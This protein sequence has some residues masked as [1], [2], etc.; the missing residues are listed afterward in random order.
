MIVLYRGAELDVR[1]KEES[2]TAP[3]FAAAEG[4]ADV[5]QVLL[6]HGADFK[7]TDQDGDTALDSAVKNGHG[8]AAKV[9]RTDFSLVLPPCW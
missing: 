9:L 8:E 2:F 4:Q 5:I 6:S 1:D 7:I 3:M